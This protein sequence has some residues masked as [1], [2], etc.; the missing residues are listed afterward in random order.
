M[1]RLPDVDPKSSPEIADAFKRTEASRG[2]VSNLMR[3]MAHSP[4][5]LRAHAAYGHHLRF[6]TDLTE[7]Q[8]ELAICATVRGV[9]YAWMHHGGLLRQ[10]GMTDAQMATLHDGKVPA[11]L[12]AA[13]AA[14]CAFIFAYASCRGVA[15]AVLAELRKHF[16]DRQVIDLALLSSYYLGGGAVITA[17]EPDLETPA[18]LQLEL[19]WQKKRL[20]G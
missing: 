7:L 20:H 13:D 17:F 1:A 3:T 19:N 6:E 9:R 11:G 5:A 18:Q 16:S 8:R 4:D 12:S 2:F 15:D 14:L 10:L